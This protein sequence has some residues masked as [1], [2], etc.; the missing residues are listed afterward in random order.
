VWDNYTFDNSA[1][2][3][4]NGPTISLPGLSPN[5]FKIANDSYTGLKYYLDALLNGFA[6]VDTNQVV[7]FRSD[8]K[9]RGVVAGTADAMQAI[10]QII[11]DSC[12]DVFGNTLWGWNQCAAVSIGLA[13]T[14][15]IRDNS[16][17]VADFSSSYV[18]G[19]TWITEQI[20]DVNWLWLLPIGAIWFFAA[21][22]LAF[23]IY[24]TSRAELK[25][26]GLNS[27]ALMFISFTGSELDSVR[28]YGMSTEG[29]QKKAE[30]IHVQLR[31]ANNQAIFV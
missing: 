10:Y 9:T 30:K 19:T 23:T 31:F 8:G 1:A 5:V 24:Q 18:V 28:E 22:L 3:P 4:W 12:L 27:L 29:L 16:F 17:D 25:T 26:W 14:K 13:M 6:Y 21:L 11:P 2:A 15:A 7:Q 20:V